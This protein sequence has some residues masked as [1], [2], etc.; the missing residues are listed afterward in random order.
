MIQWSPETDSGFVKNPGS[1]IY[2][3]S[4]IRGFS[5]NHL[6]GP[7]CAVLGD[8][9][10]MPVVGAVTSSP[11]ASPTAYSSK[12]SHTNEQ[13]SPGFYAVSLD[14]GVK[15]QLTVTTRAGIGS[16]TFPAS[17][18]ST[19]LFEVGRNAT[20]VRN[21][22]IE[23]TG[24]QRISGSVVTG[25]FCGAPNKYTVYF[26]AEFNRPLAKF[27]TWEGSAVNSG[28]RFVSGPHTGGFVGFDT[29]Q[30]QAV[31]LKVALSYV[32]VA[33]ARKNL[34]QE[35]PGWDFEMARKAAHDTWNHELG[36]IAV[37]G[38]TDEENRVFYTALYHVLLQPNVFS[39]VNDGYIG[40]DNRIHVAKGYT[41]YANFSG[42]DVYRD[43]VQLLA[44]LHP[45]ETSDMM[46]SLVMDEQQGGGLPIWPVAN[47]EACQMV[48]NPS[49]AIIA[50]AYAFGARSF[51]TRAALK[52]MLKGATQPDVK[53][54][55]C[56]EWDSL[57]NYLKH[58]YLSVDDRG[59]QSLSGP[60]QT[61]EFTTA[62][63]SIAQIAK[64]LGET[65]TYQTFM[66]R[67]QFW[68]NTFNTRTG[69][70][71]PRRKN[72]S[73]IS[74]DPA[75][76]N[77]YVEGNAAQYSWMVPYNL[78]TLFDLMGGN[79]AVVKRLDQF[80]T[81][82]N[83]GQDRPYFWIGNEPVFAVPWAYDF[84]EAPWGAQAVARRVENELYTSKPDGLPGSDDLGA[85]SAWYV[86]AAL[87]GY[88]AIPGVGGLC[89]DSPLFANAT[90]HL[91]NGQVIRIDAED[92]SPTNPY[93]Q[94]LTL[95]GKPYE[96]TWLPYETLSQGATLQFKLG[97]TPNRDWGSKPDDAPPSFTQGMPVPEK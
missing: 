89:L 93:V 5:L 84:A 55:T 40:F 23:F 87:G 73:F 31:E 46:E 21:A 15:I 42:W 83:A 14:S 74:V 29:T 79:T 78:R 37:S 25:A 33:N 36:G 41:Q 75:S 38:G 54:K 71:E 95:D 2:G 59:Q 32:S 45:K 65:A 56:L 30:D 39:D 10:I 96:R 52:A 7:G 68:R 8:V 28:R 58:G 91:G 9:P 86:F 18:D 63:F 47:D 35:I 1:Y 67:A 66:K 72:G 90:V 85:M 11:T 77:Y 17:A 80:F 76:P 16:F 49:S 3:D 22:T 97:A 69:Y 4:A 20:G 6:S 12:F 48:G 34:D 62:D 70:I 88:P 51:D 50:D 26:A 24:N 43:E 94:S 92:A 61:L 53:S 27:G 60:S 57:E 64:A 81:E 44:L 13:A 19:F 82:L